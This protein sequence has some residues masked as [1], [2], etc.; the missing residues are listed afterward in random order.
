MH[1]I[2]KVEAIG[3]EGRGTDYVDFKFD[4]DDLES[5]LDVLGYYF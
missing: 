1:S 4:D 3:S 5:K 2:F